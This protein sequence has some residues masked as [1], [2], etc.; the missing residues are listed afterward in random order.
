MGTAP[1]PGHPPIGAPRLQGGHPAGRGRLRPALN[2]M[3]H[4]ST[5]CAMR[6]RFVDEVPDQGQ[7]VSSE[8]AAA[9]VCPE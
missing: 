8:R 1:L 4:A 5:A 7:R 2:G 9:P 3:V 6:F